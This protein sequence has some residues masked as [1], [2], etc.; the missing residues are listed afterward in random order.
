MSL[1]T[2]GGDRVT[3]GGIYV[4]RKI[5]KTRKV[6]LLAESDDSP[7][8]R[9]FRVILHHISLET[10]SVYCALAAIPHYHMYAVH[11]GNPM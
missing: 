2:H 7:R 1:D 3:P 11:L 4:A 5:G 9:K 6:T 10:K 8:S